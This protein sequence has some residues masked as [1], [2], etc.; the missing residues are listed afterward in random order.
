VGEAVDAGTGALRY[1]Q[2][3][4]NHW[5]LVADPLPAMEMTE[6]AGGQSGTH[7]LRNALQGFSTRRNQSSGAQHVQHSCWTTVN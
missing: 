4:P 7:K 6:S 5:Q 2:D 3:A 1:E